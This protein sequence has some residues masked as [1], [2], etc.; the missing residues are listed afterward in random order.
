VLQNTIPARVD[1]MNTETA[2]LPINV[3]APESDACEAFRNVI[4]ELKERTIL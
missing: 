3:T 1:V 4:A 2:Y